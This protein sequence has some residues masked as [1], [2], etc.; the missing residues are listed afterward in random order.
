MGAEAIAARRWPALR[1]PALR[2]SLAVF[3]WT[4]LLVLVV[5]VVASAV[6]THQPRDEQSFDTPALTHPFVP[7]LLSPLARWDGV[8]FLR[9]AAHG[10]SGPSVTFFPLYPLLVRLV[11][12]GS[13]SPAPLLVASYVVSL[14]AFA[15]ALY[16][17]HRLV[18]VELGHDLARRALLMLSLFPAALFFG[19]PFSES[20]F[21]L[22]SVGAFYAARVGRLEWAGI[23]AAL[24]SAT[25]AAGIALIVPLAI[26]WWRSRP[27]RRSDLVFVALAPFG[28][29]L[30]SIYL[31][32]RMGDGLAWV[33]AEK[34]WG[35]AF[36]APFAAVVSGTRA[37]FDG[38]VKLASGGPDPFSIAAHNVEDWAFLAFAVVAT[39]GVVRRLPA[40]YW[41]YSLALLG[42]PLSSPARVEPLQSLPRYVVTV[43]PLFMWTALACRSPRRRA[44]LLSISTVLLV[45]S[46]ARFASWHWFA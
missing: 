25:R 2:E 38:A 17:L 40:P 8:W 3:A 36:E 41:A 23:A 44:A 13:G 4:R 29:V 15:G 45:V 26:F 33:H 32:Q 18:T 19:A 42:L 6:L 5:A 12:G 9:I 37:A 16:L 1:S 20:L 27:R 7:F 22:L 31:A 24:A 34:L 28:L 14:A 35:R 46:T 43:F 10:Y 30:Y 11:A 21:L 39:V